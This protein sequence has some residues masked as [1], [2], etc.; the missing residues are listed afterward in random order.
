MVGI[1]PREAPSMAK[2]DKSEMTTIA[3]KQL[4]G[5][6]FL[7]SLS[8]TREGENLI[9]KLRVSGGDAAHRRELGERLEGRRPGARVRAGH[10]RRHRSGFREPGDESLRSLQVRDSW[11]PD[12]RGVTAGT[13]RL[14]SPD[15]LV[16][17]VSWTPPVSSLPWKNRRSGAS[18]ENGS[19][20][21]S[22][23]S[24]AAGRC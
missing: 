19:A 7:V 1:A 16:R 13:A 5:R 9:G 15:H 10:R 23:N 3:K 18:A 17:I 4:Q 24:I 21:G 2:E 8:T 20:S 11:R 12:Q 22:G 6:G 14:N